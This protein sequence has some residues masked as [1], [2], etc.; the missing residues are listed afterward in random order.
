MCNGKWVNLRGKNGNKKKKKKE[1]VFHEGVTEVTLGGVV[2]M[3]SL[4]FCFSFLVSFSVWFFAILSLSR[5]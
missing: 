2:F 3:Y 5:Q 4:P 1:L